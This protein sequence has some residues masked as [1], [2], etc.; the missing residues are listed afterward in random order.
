MN[1]FIGIIAGL[2][3]A[4]L[5]APAASQEQ[6]KTVP[7]QKRSIHFGK[8]YSEIPVPPVSPITARFLKS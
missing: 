8:I 2:T 1:K 5:A 6:G 3:A 7:C 4:S